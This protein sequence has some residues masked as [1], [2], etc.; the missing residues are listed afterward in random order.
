M[1]ECVSVGAVSS[2]AGVRGLGAICGVGLSDRV[3]CVWGVAW[4]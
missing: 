1:R 2:D 4:G 3:R